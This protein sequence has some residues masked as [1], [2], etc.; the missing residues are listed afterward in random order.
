MEIILVRSTW[1]AF[2][3]NFSKAQRSG[4]HASSSMEP[5]LNKCTFKL[6]IMQRD[7][8]DVRRA[9]ISY[10]YLELHFSE[11]HL[12]DTDQNRKQKQSSTWRLPG[13][14]HF[15]WPPST[16]STSLT[17]L[18]P[19]AAL[20][21]PSKPHPLLLPITSRK[22]RLGKQEPIKKRSWWKAWFAGKAEVCSCRKIWPAGSGV[23]GMQ[24]RQAGI[25]SPVFPTSGYWP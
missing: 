19:T 20:S 3:L 13:R 24:R 6:S 25:Q 10:T 14:N 4:F 22:M 11:P 1:Q 16:A 17:T 7:S 15:H 23:W 12:L 9:A 21:P 8:W 18:I 2:V 5:Q